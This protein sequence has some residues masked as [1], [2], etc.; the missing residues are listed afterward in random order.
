MGHYNAIR[1]SQ[2]FPGTPCPG[3]CDASAVIRAELLS[4]GV[5]E[6]LSMD[7]LIQPPNDFMVPLSPS[8]K[9]AILRVKWR[10]ILR[11]S[12][13]VNLFVCPHCLRTVGLFWALL[14]R[15]QFRNYPYQ[16][17]NR[18]AR[19]EVS[20]DFPTPAETAKDFWLQHGF[21]FVRLPHAA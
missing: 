14:Q 18:R 1:G 6:H 20:E 8:S 17:M 4:E 15:V 21:E 11:N 12:T 9:E 7:T 19:E 3:M 5:Y 2:L 16:D 13:R 10:F